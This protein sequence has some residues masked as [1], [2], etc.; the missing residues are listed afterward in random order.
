[1]YSTFSY[2]IGKIHIVRIFDKKLLS[3]SGMR[4]GMR[5]EE[6]RRRRRRGR[7]KRRRRGR[8]KTEGE[9]TD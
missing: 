8:N 4:M 9:R 7:R 3:S 2:N 1:M 6:V 5:G